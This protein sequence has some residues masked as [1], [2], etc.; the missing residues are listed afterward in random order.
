M[1]AEGKPLR[2]VLDVFK[3]AMSMQSVV[4]RGDIGDRRINFVF[5][6]TPIDGLNKL[7]L[8]NAFNWSIDKDVLTIH[9]DEHKGDLAFKFSASNGLISAVPIIDGPMYAQAGIVMRAYPVAWLEPMDRIEID[10]QI[11]KK[12]SARPD[13]RVTTIRFELSTVAPQWYMDATCFLASPEIYKE[14]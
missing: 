12:A 4:I 11:N 1:S 10:A 3:G 13:L 7:A 2:D 6:G 9:P 14:A 5:M 8:Q